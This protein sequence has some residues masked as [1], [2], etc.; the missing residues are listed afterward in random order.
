MKTLA[1]SEIAQTIDVTETEKYRRRYDAAAKKLVSQKAILAY[2]LKS[3]ME[4]FQD[5]SVKQIAEELIEGTPEVSTIAVH[6][7][8]PDAPLDRKEQD[9]QKRMSG[10]DRIP[11]VSVENNSIRE[12]TVRYDIHFKVCVPGVKQTAPVSEAEREPVQIVMNVEVQN[13]DLPGYPIPK[14]AVYYVARLIS[15]QRGEV[16]KNQEYGEIKKAVSIWICRDTA[17]ERSD[18]INEYRLQEICR[19]GEHREEEQNYDLM[20]IFV[21]RLGDRGEESDEPVVRLLSGLLSAKKTAA[22]KKKTL[23]EEFYIDMTEEIDQEVSSMC[24]LSEGIFEKG[25]EAGIARGMEAGIVKGREAGRLEVL[26][27]LVRDGTLT[28]SV[29]AEAAAMEPSEFEQQYN[30]NLSQLR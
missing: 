16:F 17:L 8:T 28:I 11:V 22:E 27:D 20:R 2:I 30:E 18:T 12:G 3:T 6:Q 21:L 26:F 1:D 4:E 19:R 15:A 9:G 13:S 7:D 5:V 14:R 10:S 29:A 25:I 24:N 23:S